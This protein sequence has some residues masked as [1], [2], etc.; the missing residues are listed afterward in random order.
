MVAG[1]SSGWSRPKKKPLCREGTGA[2][3]A[4]SRI[5]RDQCL[6]RRP[7]QKPLGTRQRRARSEEHTSELQS[8]MRISYAVFF[9]EINNKGEK[10]V[11]ETE[12]ENR[13]QTENT[14]QRSP[15]T[16]STKY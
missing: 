6:P 13:Q 8:L 1:K 2:G 15:Q 5:R 7:R 9:L 3:E 14:Q 11:H 10:L 4:Q 16:S 12:A